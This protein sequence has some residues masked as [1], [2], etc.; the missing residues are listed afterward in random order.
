M[1]TGHESLEAL[2][3]EIGNAESRGDKPFFEGLLAPSFAFRR[4]TGVV[5]D[6]KQFLDAVVQGAPD[7]SHLPARSARSS[8]AS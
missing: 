1:N 7:R 5:V 8:S 3:V 2:N 4:V 6:R